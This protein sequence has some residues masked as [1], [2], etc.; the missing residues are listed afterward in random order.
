MAIT[1]RA[2]KTRKHYGFDKSL[3]KCEFHKY[4]KIGSSSCVKCMCYEGE[5]NKIV[6]CS[7]PE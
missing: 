2:Y 7:F 4:I 1:K 5:E 3:T 6:K